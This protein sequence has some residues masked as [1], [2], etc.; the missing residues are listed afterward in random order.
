MELIPIFIM[1]F[2]GVLIFGAAGII[3]YLIIRRVR[4]MKTE[5]FE[6]RDN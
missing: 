5:E 4:I 3:I 2:Y 1:L 6:D